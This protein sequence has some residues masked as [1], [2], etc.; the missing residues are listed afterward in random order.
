MDAAIA[1][2]HMKVNRIYPNH[3]IGG[4]PRDALKHLKTSWNRPIPRDGAHDIF[5]PDGTN[6]T[7]RRQDVAEYLYI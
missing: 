4:S 3:S 7:V 5:I 1:A 2:E 6:K